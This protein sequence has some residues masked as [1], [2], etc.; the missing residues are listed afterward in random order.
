MDYP[1]EHI[2]SCPNAST[3]YIKANDQIFKYTKDGHFEQT[4]IMISKPC[5]RIEVVNIDSKDIILALSSENSFLIDGKEIT[6]NITSF[7]IHSD[8]LLLTTLQHTLICVTLN[9]FGIKQLSKH[10]L[11][12][13]P[14]LNNTNEILFTGEYVFFRISFILC[15]TYF[16]NF[17]YIIT[18][19]YFRRLERDSH[20]IAA[21]PYESKVILQMPRGNLECIQPRA[22]LLHIIKCYLDKCNYLAALGIMTKQ[23]IN[24]NLIYDH[25]PQLFLDNVE[26]FIEDIVQNR[27]LIWL[28]MFLSDLQNE[29]VSSTMYA[30]CYTDRTIKSDVR[31]NKIT[32]DKVNEICEIL[33]NIMEKH[34]D[35]D[36][37]IQSILISFVR[38]QQRQGLEKALYKVKQVKILEDSQKLR[39]SASAY[40]ALKYLLHFVNI[41]K[42]YDVALGMYDL[43][44]AMFIASKSSKD[45]KEYLPFMNDLKKLNENYMKYSVNIYLKRYES[46]LEYLSKDETKFKECLDLIHNQKL[47]KTAIKLFEKNTTEHKKVAEI[48]GEFLLNENKYLDAGMMFYRSGNLNKALEIFN[49]SSDNWQDIITIS[50][51]M[52]LR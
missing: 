32:A 31:T 25:N 29:D 37:L 28:N 10:D 27:K 1:I 11:T 33:R 8:F 52:K 51:E 5:V 26:K 47:Y 18:D 17:K 49:M 44:L 14:W 23:R 38:T 36:N 43:D 16:F 13:K 42:L 39:G 30:Y 22:L 34:D 41:E 19:I 3:A 40:E 50:K 15:I 21:V 45:P 2:V 12:I 4:N 20:I 6:K 24:L 9:Q 46:A 7:Y 35:A 48:Y